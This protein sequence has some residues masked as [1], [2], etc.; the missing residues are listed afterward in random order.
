[1]SKLISMA[2]L[3]CILG[4]S[5]AA[6]A[7]PFDRGNLEF[8][9]CVTAAGVNSWRSVRIPIPT[10]KS[11]TRTTVHNWCVSMPGCA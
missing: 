4:I 8:Q 1:M 9:K 5:S 11:P 10:G 6:N 3:A 2:V 7:L